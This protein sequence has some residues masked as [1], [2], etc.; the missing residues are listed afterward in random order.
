[1]EF[2]T[3]VGLY[4]SI[5]YKAISAANF[6]KSSTYLKQYSAIQQSIHI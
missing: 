2:E 6:I 1:M 4:A 5:Y 3:C